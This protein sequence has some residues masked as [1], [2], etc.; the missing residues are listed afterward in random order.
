MTTIAL[1]TVPDSTRL[2]TASALQMVLPRLVA[3]GLLAKQ[4]NWNVTGPAFLPL[5]AIT[6]EIAARAGTWADRVAERAT[7]L[8]YTVDARPETVAAVAGRFPTG[9]VTD[10]EV[11]GEL[12]GL[13]DGITA[14]AYGSLEELAHTDAVSHDL[15]VEVLEGLETY[16]W[17]LQ[18]QTQ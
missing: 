12:V 18:A 11:I 2:I 13:I 4:A 6:D 14:P 5:H 10:H 1:Q 17:M 9:R 15:V 3:L 8:G 16:R 7:A